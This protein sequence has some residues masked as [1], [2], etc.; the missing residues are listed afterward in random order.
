MARF[1]PSLRLRK[2][3]GGRKEKVTAPAGYVNIFLMACMRL[4]EDLFVQPAKETE[5]AVFSAPLA[6][7][8]PGRWQWGAEGKCHQNPDGTDEI[9]WGRGRE[10]E[11]W[12]Q[13]PSPQL[14]PESCLGS[15]FLQGPVGHGGNHPT[16]VPLLMHCPLLG[17]ASLL[18]PEAASQ[19]GQ[20]YVSAFI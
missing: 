3:E 8:S 11:G 1:L 19:R 9:C 4:A 14:L 17:A 18:L 16:V 5:R 12:S 6:A 13:V 10:R 15:C 20:S 7:C 2:G